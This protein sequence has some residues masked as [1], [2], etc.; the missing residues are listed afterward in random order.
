MPDRDPLDRLLDSA[1]S[2]YA[3]PGPALAPSVLAHVVARNA[4]SRRTR[5]FWTA[6]LATAAAA[7]VLLLILAP[8]RAPLPPHT[9]PHTQASVPPSQAPVEPT[10]ARPAH[11]AIQRV[12]AA[13]RVISNP[14]APLPKQ[15]T[16][17]APSPLSNQEQ[18]LIQLVSTLPPTQQKHL[19]ETQQQPVEPLHIA[20]ISIPPLEP[21][22]Q[23]ER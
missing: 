3:D 8:W 18:A 13:P 1:L 14:P 9:A 7:F 10:T 15:Q 6:G 12:H 11:H 5:W 17:P 16:F 23:S 2:T 22:P 4:A 20:A 19:S 21:A